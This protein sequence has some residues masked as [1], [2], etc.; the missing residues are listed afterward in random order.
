METR[1]GDIKLVH[2]NNNPVVYA[3]VE[4]ISADVKPGWWQVRLMILQVPAREVT[5]ILRDEYI[6]GGEFTMDGEPMQLK[7]VAPPQPVSLSEAPEDIDLEDGSAEGAVEPNDE[8]IAEPDQDGDDNNDGGG[9][10]VDLSS[11]RRK[12]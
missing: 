7:P 10:V 5:W 6:D 12:R 2:H 11:R 8:D 9:K 1:I 3:R 4:E